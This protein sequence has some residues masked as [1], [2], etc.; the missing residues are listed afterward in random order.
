MPG[1]VH[2]TNTI[3][4]EAMAVLAGVVLIIGPWFTSI[5]FFSKLIVSIIGVALIIVGTRG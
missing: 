1:S 2:N 3:S 4:G 5:G